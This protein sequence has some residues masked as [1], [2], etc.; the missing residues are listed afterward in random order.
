LTPKKQ[1]ANGNDLMKY[2]GMA[3]EMALY[4]GVGILIG[5]VLDRWLKTSR[6]YL[7]LLFAVVFITLYFIRLIKDLSRK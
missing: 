5:S 1:S 7:T 6:P 2:S 3:F 4:I